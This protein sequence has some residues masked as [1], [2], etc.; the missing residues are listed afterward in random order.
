MGK[1]HSACV[2]PRHV[3]EQPQALR[4]VR[5]LIEVA[6]LGLFR[7]AEGNLVQAPRCSA[8]S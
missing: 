2:Q 4:R 7:V 8:A 6:V 3:A 1:L 5:E